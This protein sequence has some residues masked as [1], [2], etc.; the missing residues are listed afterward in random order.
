[1]AIEDAYIMSMLMRPELLKSPKSIRSALRAFDAIRRPRTQELVRRSRRQGG[2]FCL[3]YTDEYGLLPDFN[4]NMKWVWD[5]DF[6]EMVARA[7]RTFS[8]FEANTSDE[9]S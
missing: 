9:L 7:E 8:A 6:D 2:V 3:Q 1:M 4:D 5:V